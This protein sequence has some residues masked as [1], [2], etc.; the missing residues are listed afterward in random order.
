MINPCFVGPCQTNLTGRSIHPSLVLTN[1]QRLCWLDHVKRRSMFGFTRKC[2]QVQVTQGVACFS[3]CR[4]NSPLC[5]W[6]LFRTC[7]AHDTI[8][9]FG[10]KTRAAQTYNYDQLCTGFDSISHHPVYLIIRGMS[11]FGTL[12]CH[13]IFMVLQ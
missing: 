9:F 10:A 1:M 13:P 8:M 12:S 5:A 2:I 11:Y 6:A 4:F 3:L 7:L